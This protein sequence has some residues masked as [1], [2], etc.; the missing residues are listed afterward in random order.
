MSG[1][2]LHHAVKF[3]NRYGSGKYLSAWTALFR[4]DELLEDAV[5]LKAHLDKLEPKED[6]SAPWFGL[7]IVSYYPVGYVTCLEWHARSRL[8][9]FLS[10]NPSA[11]KPEDLK[12]VK[13]KVVV[14]MLAANLTVA[15]VVGAATNVSSFEDYMRIFSRLLSSVDPRLDAF[16]AITAERTDTRK[17]WVEEHEI[18]ELKNLYTFRN[19]LVHEIGIHRVGHQNVRDCLDPAETIRI[20]QLVRRVIQALEASL[21]A[22]MQPGF[23]NLLGDDGFPLSEWQRLKEELPELEREI[24]RLTTEFTE[25]GVEADENWEVAVAASEQYLAKE[26]QF[27]DRASMF[28]SRYIEMRDPLRVALIKSRHAYLK[29]LLAMIYGGWGIS[30]GTDDEQED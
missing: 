5:A 6:R 27:L 19:E 17:P 3:A 28:H 18:G 9:D 15:S 23:P 30:A 14:E 2:E 25:T 1:K 20:G 4:L 12:V 11:F 22:S 10:F 24:G 26:M 16:K 7:E 21:S 29:E 13:D 8:V